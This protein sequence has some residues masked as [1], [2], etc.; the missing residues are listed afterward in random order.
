[1][2]RQ[3]G[4]T[5]ALHNLIPACKACNRSKGGRTVDEYRRAIVE[6]TMRAITTARQI[7]D[8]LPKIAKDVEDLS[9]VLLHAEDLA[10]NVDIVFFGEATTLPRKD[11]PQ[12][13]D[14]NDNVVEDSDKLQ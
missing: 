14:P 10:V 12:F 5:D 3:R 11:D 9:E 7:V 2:G 8:A 6:R 1:L 13:A 4:G